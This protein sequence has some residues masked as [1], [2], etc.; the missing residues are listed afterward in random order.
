MVGACVR[1]L[2]ACVLCV[3]ACA[4]VYCCLR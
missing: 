1:V 3:R 4:R 2:C